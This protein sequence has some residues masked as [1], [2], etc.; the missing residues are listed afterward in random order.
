MSRSDR[1]VLPPPVNPLSSACNHFYYIY[2]CAHAARALTFFEDAKESKQ[3]TLFRAH[4][5]YRI[6]SCLAAKKKLRV[7]NAIENLF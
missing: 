4:F 7:E 1:G 5:L 3:R 2:L 6:F